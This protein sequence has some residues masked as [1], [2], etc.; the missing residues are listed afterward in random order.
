M[1]LQEIQICQY[2]LFI[3][4]TFIILQSPFK[5]PHRNPLRPNDRCCE[6]RFLHRHKQKLQ[7]S[8]NGQ[9][10][11]RAILHCI[12]FWGHDWTYGL[13]LQ[14]VHEKES[15]EEICPRNIH[16][17]LPLGVPLISPFAHIFNIL[18][19]NGAVHYVASMGRGYNMLCGIFICVFGQFL[20]LASA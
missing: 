13:L 3:L 12:D 17:S 4:Q 8:S 11:I 10:R 16:F 20:S 1:H 14:S 19:Y 5:I 18:I 15:E 7:R 6:E 9:L 2:V